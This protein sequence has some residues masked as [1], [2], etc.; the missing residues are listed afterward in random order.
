ML[1]TEFPSY[2]LVALGG[3][4]EELSRSVAFKGQLKEMPPACSQCANVPG[5]ASRF[6]QMVGLVAS[7]DELSQLRAQWLVYGKRSETAHGSALHGFEPYFGALFYFD[8]VP[9]TATSG[10]RAAI[11][12]NDPAQVFTLETLP[13]VGNIAARLVCQAL[14]A[15]PP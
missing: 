2:A 9:P 1:T 14:N 5:A 10:R 4:I 11:D 15:P 12:Q 6:W 13:T 3:C 8:Y 7:P